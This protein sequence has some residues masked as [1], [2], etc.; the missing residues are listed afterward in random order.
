MAASVE[1]SSYE[2]NVTLESGSLLPLLPPKPFSRPLPPLPA[3]SS[4]SR[5][6]PGWTR[7]TFVLPAA[8]PR[9][10]EGSIKPPHAPRAAFPPPDEKG[11]I[12]PKQT[13]EAL[14]KPQVDGFK[15]SVSLEDARELKA[16]EQLAVVVNRYRPEKQEKR[17]G[18]KALTLVFSHANGFYKEVWEPTLSS[19]LDRLETDGKALPVE[20]VWALD[21]INQGDSAVLNDE[22][23][24]DVFNWADHGRDLLNFIISYIDSPTLSSPSS[25]STPAVLSPASSVPSAL[26]SLDTTPP[27]P[28]LSPPTSRTYRNRLIVAIGHSLG[29]GATAYASTALPSLFSSVIFVDPVL[30][31]PDIQTR[32]MEKLT[33]GALVRREKWKSRE[34]AMKGFT[35]KPFFAAWDRGVLEGYVE[36]GLREVSGGVA[37]K[38]TARNEALT[39]C[40]PMAVAARR[41]C[42][43]LVSLPPTLPVHFIFADVNRSVLSEDIILHIRNTAV[44]HAT[45][46]RVKGAG[47]LVVHEKPEETARLIKEVLE[48]T[49]PREGTEEGKKAKL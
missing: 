15:Q 13:F 5:L 28:G 29:G 21:C 18:E 35:K 9:S 49:Y 19:L 22:V 26:F 37:L 27:P 34:E 1:S 23:L 39:F 4:S 36:H 14:V 16:Q 47:H 40:D 8:F 38:M 48:R 33:T 24:G 7:V 31:T 11:R 42:A 43:R 6:L 10:Y 20:E 25:S 30:P 17:E 44:P 45:V 3:R 46:S 41:A 32:A 12:N 2:H